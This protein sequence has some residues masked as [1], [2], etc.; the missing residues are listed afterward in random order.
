MTTTPLWSDDFADGLSLVKASNLDGI[1]YANPN[2]PGSLVGVKDPAGHTWDANPSQMFGNAALDPFTVGAVTDSTGAGSSGDAV[3]ITCQNSTPEQQ[4][5]TGF[6]AWGGSL[7]LNA[8][9]KYF[10]VGCYVEVRALFKGT[11]TN[12]WPAL[13]FFAAAGRKSGAISA[14]G[15]QG[16]E[17]DLC[18]PQ[19]HLTPGWVSMHMREAGDAP[20]P[21]YQVN[22]SSDINGAN[23]YG[24]PVV[25]N[26]WAEYGLDWQEDALT[27]YLN[28]EVVKV[29]T[30]PVVLSYFKQAK[31]AFRADYTLQSASLVTSPVSMSIDYIREWASFAASVGTTPPPPPPPPPP[32]TGPT[33]ASVDAVYASM[34]SAVDKD[35]AAGKA[36]LDKLF[37][38]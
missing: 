11:G 5:E 1:W 12:L 24:F 17:I 35:L 6:S 34:T 28:R 33:Q 4:S 13:W 38:G 31:M 8:D 36:A 26:V 18:E 32:P 19:G 29:E 15:F 25:E 27:F 37:T 2:S 16:A 10:T 21:N 9:W 3:T 7:C 20:N 14:N 23:F 22:G 30:N